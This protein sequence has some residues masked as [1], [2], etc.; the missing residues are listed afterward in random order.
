MTVHSDLAALSLTSTAKA[1]GQKSGAD[2]SVLI[3]LAH[4]HIIELQALLKQI[5]AFHPSTGGD[6][7][8]YAALLAVLG[9]LT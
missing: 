2:L 5:I 6:A 7:S 3:G 9:E 1:A 8:N 4:Q